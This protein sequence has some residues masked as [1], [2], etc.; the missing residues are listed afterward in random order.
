M[1]V[2][3]VICEKDFEVKL[4]TRLL[5]ERTGL[6]LTYFVCPICKQEYPSFYE[7]NATKELQAKINKTE[8]QFEIADEIWVRN[9][10]IA[11]LKTFRTQKK[12][13]MEGLQREMKKKEAN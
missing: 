4:L 2:N 7:N 10:L 13:L 6:E 1:I 12:K 11:K 8:K 3:C 5:D 9:A